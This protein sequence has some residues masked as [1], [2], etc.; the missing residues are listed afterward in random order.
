MGAKLATWRVS[1]EM[2]ADRRS[3]LWGS[4]LVLMVHDELVAELRADCTNRLHDAAERMAELMRQAMREVAP[5]L[6]GA[7]EAEPALSRVLSK[8]SATVR[9][10]TGRLMVWEPEEKEGGL[11]SGTVTYFRSTGRS[12]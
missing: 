5:D 4:R 12:R 8:E 7:I 10:G 11:I 1:R 9:D 6:A 3:P 2:Y